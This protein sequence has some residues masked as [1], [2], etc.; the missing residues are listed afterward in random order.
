MYVDNFLVEGMDAAGVNKSLHDG[1]SA[2]AGAGLPLHP[3]TEAAQELEMQ[4]VL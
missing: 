4:G 2:L 3:A 1:A